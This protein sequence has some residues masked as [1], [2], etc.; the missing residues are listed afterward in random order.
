MSNKKVNIALCKDMG[1]KKCKES[2]TCGWD[3]TNCV[4]QSEINKHRAAPAGP[5]TAVKTRTDRT[6]FRLDNY[7]QEICDN[8]PEDE[9][10][11]L[12]SSGCV[13]DGTKCKIHD[14]GD[15]Q[16]S[17]KS[18]V[19]EPTVISPPIIETPIIETPVTA[20]FTAMSCAI[21]SNNQLSGIITLSNG[22]VHNVA[23]KTQMEAPPSTP[24]GKFEMAFQSAFSAAI[25][26]SVSFETNDCSINNYGKLS[27]RIIFKGKIYTVVNGLIT[28]T[29]NEDQALA[30]AFTE[31]F[32]K[33]FANA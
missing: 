12:E 1:K 19:T 21:D 28:A 13:W 2:I 3:G 32:K 29:Q 27:G 20:T 11:D 16:S 7:N 22:I 14:Q 5:A 9:C 33:A 31:A 6:V 8:K 24:E 25:Q 26:G 18:P 4:S 23:K 30:D 15:Q 10:K 17:L